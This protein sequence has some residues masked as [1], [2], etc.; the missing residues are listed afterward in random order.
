MAKL[1]G[2]RLPL[3]ASCSGQVLVSAGE[4]QKAGRRRGRTAKGTM[5]SLPVQSLA[6]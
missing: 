5:G 6:P 4:H 2:L 1:P 3:P